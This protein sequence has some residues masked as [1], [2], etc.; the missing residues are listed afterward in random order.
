M[1]T[2]FDGART[3]GTDMQNVSSARPGNGFGRHS[4][5][6]NRSSF[7]HSA[8]VKYQEAMQELPEFKG[9]RLA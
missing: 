9:L 1:N 8:E 7:G 6:S 5:P 2:N 4:K 3:G